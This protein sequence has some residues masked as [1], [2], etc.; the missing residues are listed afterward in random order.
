MLRQRRWAGLSPRSCPIQTTRAEGA[1]WKLSVLVNTSSIC[2]E[3]GI[4]ELWHK[5]RNKNSTDRYIQALAVSVSCYCLICSSFILYFWILVV[6]SIERTT[7]VTVFVSKKQS[8]SVLICERKC[9]ITEQRS[10]S[11]SMKYSQYD[12]LI[13]MVRSRL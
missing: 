12:V 5:K 8:S 1:E 9:W 13:Q 3:D 4:K 6:C 10:W 7:K 2:C 11:N